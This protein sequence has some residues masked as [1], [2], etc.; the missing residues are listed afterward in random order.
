[1]ATLNESSKRICMQAAFLPYDSKKM[2]VSTRWKHDFI[3]L[4]SKKCF[5]RKTNTS[6]LS[7]REEEKLQN[8]LVTFICTLC[9][10]TV[11]QNTVAKSE[12]KNYKY[13]NSVSGIIK[14]AMEIQI[15][16]KLTSSIKRWNW[17]KFFYLFLQVTKEI[18][19][20]IIFW[21]RKP[22]WYS[23]A[24]GRLFVWAINLI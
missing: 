20:N 3:L 13:I 15:T 4:S 6:K 22:W 7:K 11:Y 16:L 10:G 2:F 14:T 24:S 12:C 21:W 5:S 1:M 18:S 17:E 19:R 23:I 9:P 8:S